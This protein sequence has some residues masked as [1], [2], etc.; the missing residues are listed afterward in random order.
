M[1]NRLYCRDG[2]RHDFTCARLPG[3]YH[4][5]G[6]TLASALA[7]RL[8]LGEELTSAVRS[9]LDYTAHAARCRAPATASTCRAA[10]PG[11]GLTGDQRMK[12]SSRLRGLYAIT[13]SKLLADGRLLPYV[14]A[15]LKGGA[16]LLQYRD[17]TSDEARRLREADALQ[18]LCA[19]HGAQLIINDDA[20]AG[21]APG[22]WPALAEDGSLAAAGPCSAARRSSV[23]PVMRNC[24]WPSRRRVTAPAT[25]PSAVS[26]SPHQ[27]RR[28]GSQSRIA[29]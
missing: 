7:G 22:R 14:E 27:T 9:A 15:A 4:G 10:C 16:R 2:S 8:A 20:E 24:R 5:S 19:R 6:C 11:P 29:A 23:P 13:D 18:E 3:S 17:K 12:E 1:H 26:S 25:S 21:R 28:T